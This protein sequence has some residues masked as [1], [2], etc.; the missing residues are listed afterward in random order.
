MRPTDLAHLAVP[1]DPQL[2]PDGRRIAYVVS[3]P[4][5]EEDR[6]VRRVHVADGD[7]GTAFTHG[8]GDTTPRWSPD[9]RWLAFLRTAA[10]DDA[11][12]QLAV[13]PADGGEATVRTQLPLGVSD[14]AWSPD[15]SQLVVV[16]EEWA[17]ELADLD[18][19]ERE[20]VPKRITRLPYRADQGG[21]VHRQRQH[22][23]LV[24]RQDGEPRCLTPGDRRESAPTWRPDGRAIAYLVPVDDE[25]RPHTRVVELDLEDG[26]TRDLV[27]PGMWS[28][29]RYAPEG[30]Q[31]LLGGLESP[32]DWPGVNVL[33]RLDPRVEG[34]PAPD[35]LTLHL[36]RDVLGAGSPPQVIGGGV[37]TGLEDRGTVGLIRID[38]RAAELPTT[39]ELVAG[40]R[41]VTGF[42]VRD[43]GA[44]AFTASDP[45][46]PGEL[47]WLEGGEERQLT[48][49]GDAF[50][51]HVD[52]RP[53]ERFTC[54][55]DGVELDVWAVLPPGFETADPGT[56][57]VIFNVHGGPTAQYG[58]EFFDEFQVEAAAGHLV[59]ATNPRGSSGRG[60]D[61]ARAVVGA[62]TDEA[63][64]D[65]L[66][67]EVVV[68]A[69]L[70]R[71]PQADGERVGVMG[72]S[73]GGYA[74]ARLLARTDRYAA[75]IVERGLL[76]WESFSGTSDIGPY[77]DEMFL[78]SSL[79]DGAEPHHAASP[80]R[81]AHRISTPTLILHSEA[82]FRCPIEQAE[83]LFVA[84]KRAGVETE[85]L[86][87]PGEG[88]ELSR[89]G[90]PRHRVER[91]EAV[92]EW[93]ERHLGP[94]LTS[95]T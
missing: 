76:Q 44:V 10:G 80:V 38:D 65:T 15:G 57:P 1:A 18:E 75:A 29:V 82:D 64:V 28:L 54:E 17:P 78:G 68:D 83:Q 45:L 50:R 72:G 91:F 33:W 22:L 87:F 5:P 73:Y 20:R 90:S 8:P 89:S 60:T 3:Q 16:G 35:P 40:A 92:L 11:R 6:Y 46:T 13:M 23:W 66:D 86:R 36:D 77:F 70:A 88:H 30:Q 59:V 14:L 85:L 58:D 24:D 95:G 19:E 2:H 94:A 69:A 26:G 49:F 84:L 4:D 63:S 67:L 62:W 21:Y 53:T 12:P 41:C 51:A 52:V 27:K 31:V 71:Y 55:R 81:T 43:D 48:R 56:V 9:G 42:A 61:W 34:G 37:I 79:A 32:Y 25:L 93:H 74:T 39:T 7:A 47:Y